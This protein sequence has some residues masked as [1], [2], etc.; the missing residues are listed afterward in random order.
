MNIDQFKTEVIERGIVSVNKREKGARREGG[1]EGFELC[2]SLSTHEQFM[3]VLKD[4]HKREIEM[5]SSRIEK[6]EEFDSD[7]YWRYRYGTLQVEH[8]LER[9][10]VAWGF[11][12]LSSLAVMQYAEIVGV[13]EE[14]LSP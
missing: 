12:P 7:A 1:I 2:R 6:R 4:R 8:V 3:N 13:K 9:M 14:N 11:S 10:K 5:T